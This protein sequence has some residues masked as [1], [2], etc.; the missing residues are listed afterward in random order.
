MDNVS[1]NSS[2]EHLRVL[3]HALPSPSSEGHAFPAVIDAIQQ[4]TAPNQITW[5]NIFH[6]VSGKFSLAD[7]PKSPPSTP[8]PPG[9]GDDYF[10]SKVFNMAVEVPDYSEKITAKPLLQ[11]K[12]RPAISPS[13]ID[14]SVVER[15][16]PPT[17][18]TEFEEL[19]SSTG[20]SFLSDRLIE[21][22]TKHGTLLFIY[23]T[24]IGGTTFRK[25][26]LAPILD[27]VLREMGT[28]HD[29]STDLLQAIGSMPDIDQ[30][31]SFEEMQA[32]LQEFCRSLS[33]DGSTPHGR[34]HAA[35]ATYRVSSPKERSPERRSNGR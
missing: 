10:T 30:L 5:M 20:R 12:L 19:F 16:I 27:P 2:S 29:L 4:A 15:Y 8:A 34:Y 21:L 31:F 13:S 17:S 24:K 14:I 25:D 3:S 1:H 32:H 22:S 26:Y 28:T 6:A 11:Q 9:E 33:I 35:G 7:L 23:P 18:P